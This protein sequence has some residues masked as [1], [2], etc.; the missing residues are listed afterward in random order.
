[1]LIKEYNR[2]KLI[3]LLNDK[4]F[5][6][7]KFIPITKGRIAHQINN[8]NLKDDDLLLF[9]IEE[10]DSVICYMGAIP[11]NIMLKDD[12]KKV[13]WLS[14]WWIHPNYS[15]T[16]NAAILFFHVWKKL[17]GKIAISS[18]STSA[19]NFYKKLNK[20]T[21]IEKK[22]YLFLFNIDEEL[23]YQKFPKLKNLGFLIRLTKAPFYII[24]LLKINI[25]N[26]KIKKS[27][28]IL[29]Y[30]NIIDDE[31][32]MFI[33]NLSE[34]ELVPKSKA[35]LNWKLADLSNIVAPLKKLTE[36]EYDFSGLVEKRHFKISYKIYSNN[37]LIGFSS[38]SVSNNSANLEFNYFSQNYGNIISDV[39]ISHVLKLKCNSLFCE[40]ELLY[41]SIKNKSVFVLHTFIFK[42][43][44]VISKDLLDNK[45]SEIKA[46]LQYG[47]G[48]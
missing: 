33:K 28:I 47:D 36:N 5:W 15:N 42:K 8:P 34:N 12:L 29:E 7:R 6:H 4:D 20:F 21:Y 46:K 18:F 32:L 11:D 19:G 35:Y 45:N 9:T 39:L 14:T 38:F 31:T 25:L 44:A 13:F 41:Q 48:G 10:G 3:E 30:T 43:D 27:G 1:M 24:N 26:S 17:A 16:S 22:R 2:K 37:E 40:D 23:V